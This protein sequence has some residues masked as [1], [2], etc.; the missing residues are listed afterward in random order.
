MQNVLDDCAANENV[1]CIL[2]TGADKAFC[3]GQDIAELT[4]DNPIGIEV[5]LVE[6]FNPVISKIR[7]SQ[8]SE[9]CAVNAVTTGHHEN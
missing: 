5:I 3:A 9:V 7:N 2:L 1:S 6:H 8:K 4:G